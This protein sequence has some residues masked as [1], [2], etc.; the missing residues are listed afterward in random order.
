MTLY[1]TSLS[2]GQFMDKAMQATLKRIE[3]GHFTTIDEKIYRLYVVR[4]TW[5]D[6]RTRIF[7]SEEHAKAHLEGR[8]PEF[9]P[10]KT[11]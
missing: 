2:C 11:P 3:T 8:E 1:M 5:E 9:V 10:F 6:G 4:V 7:P